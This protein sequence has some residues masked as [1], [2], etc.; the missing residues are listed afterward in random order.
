MGGILLEG[1]YSSLQRMSNKVLVTGA[2]GFVGRVVCRRLLDAGFIPLAAL[3]NAD[4]WPPL[5][6]AV[7]GMR[8]WIDVGDLSKAHHLDGAFESVVAV[9]HLAARVHVM[10]DESTDPLE[11]Y[12]RVNLHGTEWLAGAAA[13]AGVRRFVFVSTAKVNGEATP[14]GAFSEEDVPA[15]QDPYSVSKW[16]AEQVLRGIAEA[17]GLEVVIVRPPLVYGPGVKANFLRLMKLAARGIPLPL[18]E[19]RNRRSLLGVENLADFLVRCVDHARAANQTFLVS[20]GEDL[21]TR[22]L[23]VL[24]A[25]AL[26]RTARFL[27]LP[28]SA[29]RLVAKALGKEAAIDRLLGSLSLNS[30]KARQ[31]LDWIPPVSVEDGLAVTA[32]WYLDSLKHSAKSRK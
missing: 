13:T 15:P 9:I 24:L 28:A 16:E 12:R 23:V 21:S 5:Q 1:C 29:V 14:A 18:P 25:H 2:D 32:R 30:S 8:E 17:T 6:E 7:L 27:P 19:T 31:L 4:L 26:G 22:K 20:D 10:K 11:E 3:R